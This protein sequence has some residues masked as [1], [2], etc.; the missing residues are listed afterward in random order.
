M[1]SYNRFGATYSEVIAFWPE[2]VIGDFTSQ[3]AVE[4]V[5]DRIELEV[6]ANCNAWVR[7]S[8]RQC[9]GALVC[10]YATADQVQIDVGNFGGLA[11]DC[12]SNHEVYVDYGYAPEPP[13][14]GSGY[15]AG[16]GITVTDN[17][18]AIRITLDAAY[19]LSLGQRVIMSCDIDPSDTGFALPSLANFLRMGTAAE[20]GA[21]VFTPDESPLLKYYGDKY[22]NDLR[23]LRDHSNFLAKVPELERRKE[24]IYQGF[25]GGFM[26]GK[27]E[28]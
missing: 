3:A 28:R 13:N 12:T 25:V 5:M 15:S 9:V 8:L 18:D 4:T 2:T 7:M 1:A 11:Y 14:R 20:I 24:I 17:S 23:E 27:I 10:N 16:A 26:K 19:K 6:V 21:Q 22:K